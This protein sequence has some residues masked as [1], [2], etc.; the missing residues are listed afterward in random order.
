MVARQV[1]RT[2]G[3]TDQSRRK[4]AGLLNPSRDAPAAGR[5]HRSSAAGPTDRHA[6]TGLLEAWAQ[7]NADARDALVPLV[8]HDLRR[9][10]AAALRRERCGHTLQPTALVHEAYL[11][12][13]DQRRAAPRDRAQFFGLA[14]VVMRRIL[15]DRA[16]ARRAARRSGRWRRTLVDSGVAAVGPSEVDVIDLHDALARL[17]AVDARKERIAELRFFAGLTLAEI[18]A[19]EGI[20][21]ATV[22][23]EWQ[24][25]RAWLF[26]ALTDAAHDDA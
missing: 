13:V 24:V 4:E 11:R 21:L 22:E 14:A 23:R 25:A 17:A 5:R 12:L 7:G 8:Y 10:A 6:I 16:R 19:T 26:A 15:V 3:L 1:P 9:Q 2:S 20:S 18:A